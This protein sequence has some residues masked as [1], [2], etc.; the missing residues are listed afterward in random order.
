MW[1]PSEII[2]NDSVK[3]DPVTLNILANCPN[4]SIKYTSSGKSEDIK[5]ISDVINIEDNLLDQVV[6]G[7]NVVYISPV[8]N[9]DV[10]VLV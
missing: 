8:G 6:A 10:V 1:T 7:K 4:A 3:N 9:T 2:I 5:A